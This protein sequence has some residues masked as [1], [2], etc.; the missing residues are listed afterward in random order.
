MMRWEDYIAH[1]RSADAYRACGMRS[2]EGY[3]G[4]RAVI[5]RLLTELEPS[6]VACLGAGV[7]NDIPYAELVASGAAIHLVDWLPG[8]VDAG[9]RQSIIRTGAG[10]DPG[11]AY[12]V[13]AKDDAWSY[14]QSYRSTANGAAGVCDEFSP[15]S[16]GESGCAAFQRG[17]RP[18]VLCRDATNGY[19]SAFARLVPESIKDAKTW[20]QALGGARSAAKRARRHH[21]ALDIPDA[22]VDL[23]TSSMLISQF[24]REPYTYFARQTATRLGEPSDRDERLLSRTLDA[25]RCELF[26]TQVERHC[27]EI[28]RILAPDGYCLVAFELFQYDRADQTW[29]LVR[30]THAALE[31]L[32]ARFAFD[33]DVLP[34]HDAIVRVE[35]GSG[36]SQV[37]CFVLRHKS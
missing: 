20:K 34:T 16:K 36:P 15:M 10:G 21:T 14:C 4:L 2:R 9:I 29:F 27:D 30:E 17:T 1:P 11:C 24:D 13:L 12:C 33:F 31:I 23:V 35:L 19:A 6:S 25:L 32:Q 3:G 5:A 37:H 26:T 8:I 7:L 22:S 28:R 18:N